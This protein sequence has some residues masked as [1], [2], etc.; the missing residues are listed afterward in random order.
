MAGQ[1]DSDNVKITQHDRTYYGRCSE[2]FEGRPALLLNGGQQPRAV[3]SRFLRYIRSATRRGRR[4]GS[5]LYATTAT[6]SGVAGSREPQVEA[7]PQWSRATASRPCARGACST[8]NR[9]RP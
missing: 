9:A 5:G 7:P 6:V 2:T 4:S 8:E 1:A 3:P